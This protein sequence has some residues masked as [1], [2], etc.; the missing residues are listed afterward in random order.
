MPRSGPL[1]RDR[2]QGLSTSLKRYFLDDVS[3]DAL[4]PN[5]RFD[6]M[7]SEKDLWR[8]HRADIL[9][10]FIREHPG[11]RPSAWWRYDAPEPGRRRLG[12]IG[13]PSY[14]VLAYVP[15]Y[16]CGIPIDWILETQVKLYAGRLRTISGRIVMPE[17]IGS[18]FQGV[19]IDPDD[20]PVFESQAAFL[21]RHGLF[22]PG[23]AERLTEADFEPEAIE[24]NE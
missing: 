11:Q 9:S 15:R 12:G 13:A 23:E 19:A 18:D 21:G 6:L 3:R 1:P 2:R 10:E 14:E 8:Q 4:R 5:E 24:A 16:A 7:T 22:L 17:F 20:P